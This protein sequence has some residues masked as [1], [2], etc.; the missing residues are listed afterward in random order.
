[1]VFKNINIAV[2]V[3]MLAGDRLALNCQ[4]AT[5]KP[6]LKKVKS[7]KGCLCLFFCK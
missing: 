3:T 4:R 7:V 1:M 2:P 6:A 5:L